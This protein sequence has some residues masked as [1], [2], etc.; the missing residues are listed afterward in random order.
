MKRSRW[1]RIGL[2]AVT[3]GLLLWVWRQAPP[4][5]GSA[6]E[7]QPGPPALSPAVPDNSNPGGAVLGLAQALQSW[8]LGLAAQW[9][10]LAPQGPFTD[11]YQNVLAPALARMEI[12]LG[13]ERTEGDHAWVDVSVTA[14][15][16]GGAL[17]NLSAGAAS[18]LVSCML[19]RSQADW[20]AFLEGCLSD[21]NAAELI[22]VQRNATAYLTRDG[23][24]KW[25]IDAGHPEN[26]AFCNALTGGLLDVLEQLEQLVV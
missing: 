3:A 7:H 1:L 15:D 17:G 12:E 5:L 26:R 4:R 13:A 21:A 8:D 16:V 24:G 20:G 18:Y 14:V 22:R 11:A 6:A 25:R 23:K 9:M 10:A 2:A 19:S